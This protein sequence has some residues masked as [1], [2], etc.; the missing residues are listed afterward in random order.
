MIEFCSSLDTLPAADSAE[1]AK[2]KVSKFFIHLNYFKAE[3]NKCV[4][5]LHIL[6]VSDATVI[7][8]RSVI[9]LVNNY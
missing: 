4:T 5:C 2:S 9:Q 7:Q 1:E 8:S 6:N 3:L